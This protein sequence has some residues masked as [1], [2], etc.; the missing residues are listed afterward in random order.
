MYAA[1]TAWSAIQV[2]SRT[3]RP[4]P[5]ASRSLINA[6]HADAIGAVGRPDDHLISSAMAQQRL[7]QRRFVAHGARLRIGLR[8]PDDAVRLLLAAVL[9]ETDGASHG[10]DA[11]H[12]HGVDEHVVLDDRLELL[13]PRFPHALLV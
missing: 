4:A 5:T 3:R 6:D 8:R 9:L 10:H 13:D 1:S 2:R 11:R 7:A 12:A